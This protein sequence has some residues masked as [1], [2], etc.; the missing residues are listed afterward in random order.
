[1]INHQIKRKGWVSI[2][3]CAVMTSIC[4]MEFHAGMF[5]GNLLTHPKISVA[6]DTFILPQRGHD[7]GK[8]TVSDQ[9]IVPNTHADGILY[10]FVIPTALKRS[11]LKHATDKRGG[12]AC[13]CTVHR[14]WTVIDRSLSRIIGYIFPAASRFLIRVHLGAVG[15]TAAA[16]TPLN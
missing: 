8:K 3:N 5:S 10:G 4:L 9:N 7:A 2:Y 16:D 11:Q 13:R 12:V 15:A 1:M 14:T 6:F